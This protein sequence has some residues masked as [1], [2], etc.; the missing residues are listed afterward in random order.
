MSNKKN[1]ETFEAN[2][3]KLEVLAQELQDDE[4]SIDKLI[5]RMKEA[6]GAVKVCKNVLQE[7]NSQLKEISNEFENIN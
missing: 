3:K 1:N 5:P 2:F 6:L 4:I 7:T